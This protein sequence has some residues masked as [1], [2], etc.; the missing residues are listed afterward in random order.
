MS[1]TDACTI[2]IIIIVYKIISFIMEKQNELINFNTPLYR[3]T[4]CFMT[5]FRTK[6]IFSGETFSVSASII[7]IHPSYI[8]LDNKQIRKKHK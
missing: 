7:F 4:Y 3:W 6:Y 1:W 2:I 8:D 5:V